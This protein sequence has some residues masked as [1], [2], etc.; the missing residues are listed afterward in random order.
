MNISYSNAKTYIA[1]LKGI[2]QQI[3]QNQ[4]QE[5]AQNLN[6]LVQTNSNDPRLYLLGLRLAAMARN[7]TGMLVA[8]RRAHQLAP[9]WAIATISLA[10]VLASQGEVEEAILMAEKALRQAAVQTAQV[11]HRVEVLTKAAALAQRVG[12][13]QR[14]L[15][16]LQEAEEINPDDLSI[17]HEIG[18]ALADLG[19]TVQAIDSFNGLLRKLPN[20]SSLLY[21]RMRISL[22]AQLHEQA[23]QDGETLLALE[24]GNEVYKFYLDVA[25]GLTP[26]TQPA[27]VIADLFDADTA[28][29]DQQLMAR[30]QYTLPQEVSQ[31]ILRWHPGRKVDV[32]DLGCGTGAL[33]AC[34]G[35]VDGAL[36]GVD[37][38]QHML[39]RAV[40]HHVYDRL[41]NVNLVDALRDTPSEHYDVITALDVFIYVGDL[42]SVIPNAYRV[43]APGGRFVFSCEE[44]AGAAGQP[45][46]TL[47]RSYRYTHQRSY[48]LRLL[49]DAGYQELDID[50]RVLRQ[51]KGQ[52]VH[53]FLVSARKE[54]PKA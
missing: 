27:A 36:I 20:N 28:R 32:L 14:A 44:D 30:L 42:G 21:D 40:S 51:E 46:F 53:G 49:E 31:M 33:G 45:D 34:L 10:E 11:S 37:L 3:A 9:D 15:Q 4:L 35:S 39:D 38:S 8:A 17:R 12:L 22:D 54:P 6:L 26:A 7:P 2:E 18:R 43:L 19:D 25:R 5:A 50:D 13:R 24:P 41:H 16:W 23:I 1:Q 48:V 47:Q 52:A 29:S